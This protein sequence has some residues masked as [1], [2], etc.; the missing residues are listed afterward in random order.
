MKVTSDVLTGSSTC[1]LLRMSATR[2]DDFPLALTFGINPK[3]NYNLS[4]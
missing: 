3:E 1:K 2:T 4:I